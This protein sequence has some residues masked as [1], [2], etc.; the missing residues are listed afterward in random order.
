MTTANE[1]SLVEIASAFD[2]EATLDRVVEAIKAANLKILARIDHAANAREVGLTMPPT[3][4][5]IYGAAKGGTPVMLAVPRS[6]LDLP[7]R[8]LVRETEAGAV[9]AFHP[10]APILMK[11]GAAESL[12]HRLDPAQVLLTEAFRK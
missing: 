10:I 11:A 7:L 8:V 4:L 5:L 6:A 9:V 2:F 1:D 3:T 12:V